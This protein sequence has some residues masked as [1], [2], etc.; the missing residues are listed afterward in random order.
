M[1]PKSEKI[2]EL[3]I[4]VTKTADGL[5]DY[6]QIISSDQFRINIVLIADGIEVR[7]E[8]GN[9]LARRGRAEG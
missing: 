4:T 9:T 3:R 1:K 8:R 5:H 6:V 2:P 7:D